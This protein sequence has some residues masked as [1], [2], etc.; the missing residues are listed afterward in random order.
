M[1]LQRRCFILFFHDLLRH[2]ASFYP[3]NLIL[4]KHIHHHCDACIAFMSCFLWP[5]SSIVFCAHCGYPKLA[6]KTGSWNEITSG[7]NRIKGWTIKR[8]MNSKQHSIVV[9]FCICCCSSV[10]RSSFNITKMANANFVKLIPLVCSSYIIVLLW[11]ASMPMRMM[12]MII[13]LPLEFD[14]PR[15]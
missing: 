8:A 5:K 6:H 14:Y 11:L 13:E 15:I 12:L 9:W 2:F 7:T 3:P 10:F 4:I 1:L